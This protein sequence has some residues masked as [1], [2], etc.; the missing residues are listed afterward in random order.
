MADIVGSFEEG[1]EV[2]DTVNTLVDSQTVDKVRYSNQQ[3]H[4]AEP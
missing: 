3:L 1:Q 4:L 2:V